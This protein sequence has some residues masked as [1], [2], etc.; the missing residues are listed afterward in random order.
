MTSR[1]KTGKTDDGDTPAYVALAPHVERELIIKTLRRVNATLDVQAD[2][3]V[4]I[5]GALATL[6]ADRAIEQNARAAN[7]KALH[8]ERLAFQS[9]LVHASVERQRHNQQQLEMDRQQRQAFL[10]I[11]AEQKEQACREQAVSRAT[12]A[13]D[14]EQDRQS[15]RTDQAHILHVLDGEIQERDQLL[16]ARD[17]ESAIR[18]KIT[19][20]VACSCAVICLIIALALRLTTEG[21]LASGSAGMTLG[22]GFGRY[23]FKFILS[24]YQSV[25]CQS[26]DTTNTI[27]VLSTSNKSPN[28]S[29]APPVVPATKEMGTRRRSSFQPFPFG[30]NGVIGTIGVQAP[31]TPSITGTLPVPQPKMASVTGTAATTSTTHASVALSNDHVVHLVGRGLVEG[32]QASEHLR[33]APLSKNI[34]RSA[35]HHHPASPTATLAP[36]LA[37]QC[38]S[39]SSKKAMLDTFT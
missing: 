32:A 16:E 2:R 11:L 13:R 14:R 27:E 22:A 39:P 20:S 28:T 34:E 10:V 7:V 1:A 38:Q 35:L 37:K 33:S 19:W 36:S 24:C 17:R 3:D 6:T 29:T 15:F 12:E 8:E 26:N 4:K 18:D 23:A 30:N 21:V 25:G 9:H 5:E 31:L